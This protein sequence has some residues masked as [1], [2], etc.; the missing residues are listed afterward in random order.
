MS[1]SSCFDSVMLCS[2]QFFYELRYPGDATT[3]FGHISH[4]AVFQRFIM[5]LT[6][7]NVDGRVV[8]EQ[9]ADG[10]GQLKFILLNPAMEFKTLTEEVNPYCDEC[11]L[12]IIVCNIDHI[13]LKYRHM[14]WYYWEARCS[15]LTMLR[16]NF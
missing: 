3:S 8:Y 1:Y 14:Q 16:T 13:Y 10:E 12:M 4:L 15:R 6:N 5:T 2:V 9:G 11:E 7:F